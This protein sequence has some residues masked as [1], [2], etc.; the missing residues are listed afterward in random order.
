MFLRK[1][2]S[3]NTVVLHFVTWY[4]SSFKDVQGIFTRRHIELLATEHSVKHIVVQKAPERFSVIG[5]L[6]SLL[7][8]FVK[9]RTG[10]LE[11]IQ[12]PNESNLYE[13][14]FWRYKSK[15]EQLQINKLIKTYQPSLLH[16]HVVYGFGKEAVSIKK[17]WGI[18]FL[19]S[20]HMAPFPFDWIQDK[21]QFVTEPM[22][23]AAAVVSV[24]KAQAQEIKAF[25][26]VEPIV[27]P[28]VVNEEDFFYAEKEQNKSLQLVLVGIYDSRKGA[29]YLLR[30]LPSF[31][32]KYP[33]TI[34]HLAG[35]AKPERMNELQHII[36]S[37]GIEKAV[38]F[39]GTLN[40]SALCELYHECDMYVC[41]SEWESF[42][43]T[44]LEALFCGLPV[45]S[46]N[47]GGVLEFMN[48]EN[49]LLIPN[50]R[51]DEVLLNGLTEMARQLPSFNRRSISVAVNKQ[52]S[53]NKIKDNYYSLYKQVLQTAEYKQKLN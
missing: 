45:L 14:F 18:P 37:A 1:R 48:K 43:L 49:G 10:E 42:G 40:A 6:Q 16:L 47:C 39:H 51:T 9:R 32:K 27:I 23:Q 21:Q 26:G 13:K 52:F 33:D 30:V 2:K 24:S 41:A 50:T 8:R 38:V 44:M 11:V 28:N 36:T 20:E 19:I 29:D 4:P 46:T 17:K 15:L 12:L 34:L 31:L 3:N 25:T 35:D 7:G 53:R 22:Q 5:H